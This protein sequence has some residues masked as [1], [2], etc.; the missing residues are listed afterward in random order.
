MAL[1]QR[2]AA[3][4][5]PADAEPS[6]IAETIKSLDV[7]PKTLDDFKER[8][9]SGATISLV[10]ISVIFLLVVSELRAY[11][12]PTTTDHLYVDS[13]RSER[14]RININVSFPS[15]PCAGLSIVAMDVAG[16]QQI[17]VVSNIIKVRHKLDGEKIGVEMD[18]EHI[19]RKFARG[20]G[21]CGACFPQD[22]EFDE[23]SELCCNSC[24]DVKSLYSSKASMS[25][26]KWEEHPLCQHEAVAAPTRRTDPRRTR[27]RS[28]LPAAVSRRRTLPAAGCAG[29][30][31]P[32]QARLDPR[33]VQPLRLPRG[34]PTAVAEPSSQR[35]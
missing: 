23:Q 20:G 30:P 1:R 26:L 19:R 27:R 4:E 15:M 7:Y 31:R 21:S 29:A 33:G 11:L 13:A 32:G 34:A 22:A 28:T 6:R 2:R 14:I 25:K 16:E 5:E 12:T 3:R 35:S 17:D 10:S 24:A 9:S 8:T 18:D